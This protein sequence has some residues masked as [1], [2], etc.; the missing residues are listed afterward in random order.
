M[1]RIVPALIV[2]SAL[3]MPIAASAKGVS[4]NCPGRFHFWSNWASAVTVQHM[5]CAQAHDAILAGQVAGESSSTVYI[6]TPGF[7]CSNVGSGGPQDNGWDRIACGS[8][9]N[10][11]KTFSFTYSW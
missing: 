5:S 10:A 4:S 3:A 2:A 8:G 7:T 1:K 9:S 6:V 11:S